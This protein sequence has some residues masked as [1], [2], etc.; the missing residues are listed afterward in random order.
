MIGFYFYMLIENYNLTEKEKQEEDDDMG[1]DK[2]KNK[3]KVVKK[4][5]NSIADKEKK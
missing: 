2:E 1:D 5:F 4:F 3:Q